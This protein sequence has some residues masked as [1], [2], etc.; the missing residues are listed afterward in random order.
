MFPHLSQDLVK[1][2]N[3]NVG[4]DPNSTVIEHRIHKAIFDENTWKEEELYE[5][6]EEAFNPE[7]P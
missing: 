2:V 4:T 3:L 5:S 1:V 7:A 6:N